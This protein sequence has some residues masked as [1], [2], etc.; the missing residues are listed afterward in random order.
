MSSDP[1]MG[2]DEKL[3]RNVRRRVRGGMVRYH[4]AMDVR[5][6]R[7]VGPLR[8]TV[9][10]AEAD[11]LDLR[12]QQK[13]R[14]AHSLTLQDAYDELMQS[15]EDEGARTGTVAFYREAWASLTGD[16]GW[17]S[18]TP[19]TAISE[20]QIR[21]YIAKRESGT[22]SLR[23]VWEKDMALMRRIFRL[24]IR[25]RMTEDDPFAHMRRP[26][27]RRPRF[28]ALTPSEVYEVIGR[29]EGDQASRRATR[30]RDARI[31]ELLF[32][33]GLRRA[34]LGR[35]RVG[36]CNLR[37]RQMQVD[38]KTG[39]RTLPLVGRVTDLIEAMA[40]GK[41]D[42]D[43]VAVCAGT[44]HTRFTFW[45]TKLGLRVWSPHVLRHSFAT[46]AVESG[47]E[48]FVLAEL[49]GHSSLEMVKRYF[50]GSTDSHRR[51]LESV[52]RSHGVRNDGA[53]SRSR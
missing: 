32:L 10:E 40:D 4:A 47:V 37:L 44:I 23:T 22:A 1:G 5:G 8:R 13:R 30:V 15:L 25:R 12:A 53:A 16:L 38:G 27:I 52:E 51:A 21:R 34:E 7:Q 18:H 50:H 43:L 19:L 3:P 41:R 29:I 36:D 17:S 28:E 31:A 9:A 39:P 35:L 26:R 45:R 20:P 11:A 24:A 6:R 48:M 49:L 42:G 46:A 33:T 14:S 2:T